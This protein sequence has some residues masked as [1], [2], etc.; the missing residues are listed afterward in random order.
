VERAGS[1]LVGDKPSDL[2]AASAAGLPGRL[3][4]GGNLAAF[5]DRALP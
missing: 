1:F 4:P 5:L 3:F 2:A